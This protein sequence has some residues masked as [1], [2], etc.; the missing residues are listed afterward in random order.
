MNVVKSRLPIDGVDFDLYAFENIWVG[1]P[2]L[3][4]VLGKIEG[5]SALM[6]RVHSECMTGD[7]FGSARCDCG[8]QLKDMLARMRKAGVG[9]LI[10][11]R[12]EGRGIGLM[13]K[14]EA[15]NLQDQGLDTF[16]AN[17]ALGR[18]AD[19]R[20]YVRAAEIIRY[21]KVN[22]IE[23]VTNNPDKLESLR[24]L[25]IQVDRRLPSVVQYTAVNESYLL[26]KRNKF[27]HDIDLPN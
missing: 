17:V 25:G 21:L 19:E 12:Q 2:D 4:L 5:S 7:V 22:S 3:A 13:K 10:Y 8:L 27:H 11:L 6:T 23:L 24:H 18:L 15:Y 14:L 16:D 9:L 26:T 1:Q 20:D